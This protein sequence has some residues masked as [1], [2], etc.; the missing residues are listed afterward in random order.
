MNQMGHENAR[1]VYEIYGAWMEDMN[2]EQIEML[3]SHNDRHAPLVPLF[4]LELLINVR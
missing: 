2:S 3:N 4:E 1:M